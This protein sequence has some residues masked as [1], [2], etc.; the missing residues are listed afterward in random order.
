MIDGNRLKFG[1]G[2]IVVGSDGLTQRMSFQ[3]FKPPANCGD[4]ISGDVEYIGNKIVLEFSYEDYC[5]FSKKLEQVSDKEMTEFVFKDYV[6]DF[7]NFN[8]KS[9]EVCKKYLN[10]AMQYYFMCV[11]A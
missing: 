9:I 1:H 2:D 6:F 5:E 3:Q 11:A 7:T 8:E 4:R 10:S